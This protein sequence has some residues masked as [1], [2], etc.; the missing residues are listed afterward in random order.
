MRRVDISWCAWKEFPCSSFILNILLALL[1]S[2]VDRW[3]NFVL[4]SPSLSH[5]ILDFCFHK[6]SSCWHLAFQFCMSVYLMFIVSWFIFPCIHSL[7]IYSSCSSSIFF[8][9]NMLPKTSWFQYFKL[10]FDMFKFSLENVHLGS[11]YPCRFAPPLFYFRSEVRMTK[12]ELLKSKWFTSWGTK[13]GCIHYYG[14]V[15]QSST[16]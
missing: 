16:W 3:N 2:M 5:W 7:W 10:L 9:L 11:S 6:V 12:P 4:F 13:D 15:V 1:W 14:P 8:Y